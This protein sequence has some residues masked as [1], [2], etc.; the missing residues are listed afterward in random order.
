MHMPISSENHELVEQLDQEYKSN[1]EAVNQPPSVRIRDPKTL[2][3]YAQDSRKSHRYSQLE[4][5][6]EEPG[7]EDQGKSEQ[8]VIL[9]EKSIRENCD[10]R[11]NRRSSV[12]SDYFTGQLQ[13]LLEFQGSLMKEHDELEGELA[14]QVQQKEI[15]VKKYNLEKVN[16]TLEKKQCNDLLSQLQFLE[17]RKERTEKRLEKYDVQIQLI[18]STQNIQIIQTQLRQNE[19]EYKWFKNEKIGLEL[20]YSPSEILNT[21]TVESNS[22]HSVNND[23]NEKFNDNYETKRPITWTIS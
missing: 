9:R 2:P 20:K 15:L 16:K 6:S 18:Q 21:P 7:Q 5:V 11:N 17:Y 3:S 4:P 14:H 22:R 8:K 10:Q 23:P 1:S 12:V 13:R 19:K